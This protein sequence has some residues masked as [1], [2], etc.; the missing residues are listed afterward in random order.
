MPILYVV[1]ER[2]VREYHFFF[3]LLSCHSNYKNITRQSM[4]ECT[5]D[6]DEHS[7]TNARTQVLFVKD[8]GMFD[9]SDSF[10]DDG[11]ILGMG[12]VSLKEKLKQGIKSRVSVRLCEES[13]DHIDTTCDFNVSCSFLKRKR[14]TSDRTNTKKILHKL[15]GSKSCVRAF[16]DIA[17]HHR[18]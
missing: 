1:F 2:G 10:E 3:M 11:E 14:K 13:G 4:L 15:L 17:F 7:N 12:V 6:N 8:R 9:D 18:F 16:L 5:L